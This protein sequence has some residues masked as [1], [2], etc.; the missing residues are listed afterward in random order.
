MKK[1]K[2]TVYIVTS[3]LFGIDSAWGKHEDAV[4]R[5]KEV[6]L[7]VMKSGLYTYTKREGSKVINRQIQ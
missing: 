1:N 4:K 5:S 2:Q 6:Q 7:M 3:G